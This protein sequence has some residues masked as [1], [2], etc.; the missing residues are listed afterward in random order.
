MMN[1]KE[2]IEVVQGA[3]LEKYGVMVNIDI[4]IHRTRNGEMTEDLAEYICQDVAQ[5]FGD[6]ASA[7][8]S[9]G[10]EVNWWQTRAWDERVEVTAFFDKEEILCR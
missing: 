2:A 8:F 10:E 6:G 4:Y 7:V 5:K 3:F 1:L 9:S